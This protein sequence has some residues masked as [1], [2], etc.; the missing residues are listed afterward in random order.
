MRIAIIGIKAIPAHYGGF[1]TAVDEVSRGLVNRGHEV[2]VYNRTGM[3]KYPGRDYAGVHLVT[4]P[5]IK[6][7]HLSTIA[8]SFVSTLHATFTRAQVVHYYTTGATLFAPLPR[9][10]G[11]KIVCSADGTDWQ[12]AKWGPFARWYLR[13]SEKLA[14]R[15]CHEVIS[16]AGEVHNYYRRQYDAD[17]FCITYGMREYHTDA[18]D[19]LD[20][21][22]LKPREYVLFVGRLVPENNIHQLIRAFEQ[23]ET[24]KR[25]VIVGDDPWERDYVRRLKSTRD[26]RVLF[27]GGIYGEGYAQ[28]QQ[29]AYTFVLPDEV[30]GTHPVLVE[31][32]GFGN[33]VLVND[34]PTNLEVIGD[35][36][37]SYRG[38]EGADDLAR[39]LKLLLESPDLVKECRERALRR[40]QVNYRWD[41]VIQKHEQLYQ[42]ALH[43]NGNVSSPDLHEAQVTVGEKPFDRTLEFSSNWRDPLQVGMKRTLEVVASAIL[44]IVLSP[45]L[46]VLGAL[47]KLTS[48][49]PVFYRWVVAGKD[50]RPFTSY[51]FRSMVANADEIKPQLLPLNEMSGPMFKITN[52]P[53]I[54]R[55]GAWMRK[56]S[57][58]ELPQLYS[59]LKGDMSMVG[60]R[61][62][63]AI[64]YPRFTEYQKRKMLVKPG[65]TCLWQV[66]GRNKIRDFDEWVAM[67]LDYIQNWSLWLDLKILFRTVFVV[68]AG[69][70]K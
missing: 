55:L 65:I 47:V 26:S 20:R 66:N 21:F 11:K 15:F 9:A 53:R 2:T 69:S 46:V 18:T 40:A 39:K 37:I 50:G 24:G 36:G 42:R 68:F 30:G 49:G 38:A 13:L 43:R 41:D 8:H 60:P 52:D 12:R 58:D 25:L 51:K 6:T 19:V 56:Y 62:P 57:L 45:L 63:L 28:L 17:T 34:T 3:S 48:K 7:K 16:D 1:E 59:V 4:L 29:N 44:L 22:G 70:G 54:T 31:A 61:P 67:D 64:E 23:V 27:T 14:V 33:C 5:T 35:S 10:F 32:M